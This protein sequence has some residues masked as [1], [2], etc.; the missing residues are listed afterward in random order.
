MIVY[1]ERGI[2]LSVISFR[3]YAAQLLLVL[4]SRF[5]L[6]VLERLIAFLL[7]RCQVMHGLALAACKVVSLSALITFQ[8]VCRAF[9]SLV[10]SVAEPA[11]SHIIM[12]SAVSTS[13][14]VTLKSAD[15][16]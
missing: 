14:C 6:F 4:W 7:V 8:A 1:H 10:L 9:S 13:F 3:S 12:L 15:G 11:V 2:D 16:R 5:M